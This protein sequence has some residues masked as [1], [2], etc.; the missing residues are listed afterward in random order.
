M[1]NIVKEE[2]IHNPLV[3][4]A[5]PLITG[6]HFTTTINVNK[7]FFIQPSAKPCVMP[8]CFEFLGN[9]T[10][11]VKLFSIIQVLSYKQTYTIKYVNIFKL[12]IIYGIAPFLW[13]NILFNL[14]SPFKPLKEIFY[15]LENMLSK[16]CTVH[17]SLFKWYGN[18]RFRL[19]LKS[20]QS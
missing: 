10:F 4:D 2:N 3:S 8:G 11:Y 6:F 16:N 14:Y 9:H 13:A 1:G 12:F 19:S 7:S 5:Q 20:Q 15:P 17:F 18:F